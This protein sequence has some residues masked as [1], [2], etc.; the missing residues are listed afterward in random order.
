MSVIRVNLSYI[1]IN[2][3]Y[4]YDNENI[5]LAMINLITKYI[6]PAMVFRQEQYES[7]FH[8]MTL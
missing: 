7:T 6:T 8:H 1:N 4:Q 3:K 2:H 5:Y